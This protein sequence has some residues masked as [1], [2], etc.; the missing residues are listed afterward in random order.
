MERL[1]P[2]RSESDISSGFRRTPIEA[3]LAYQNLGAPHAG[4]FGLHLGTSKDPSRFFNLVLVEDL[5]GL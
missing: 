2:V 3:L 5:P 1:I 4:P